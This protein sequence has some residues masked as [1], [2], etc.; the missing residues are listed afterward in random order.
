[1]AKQAKLGD[2]EAYRQQLVELAQYEDER[3]Q[4]IADLPGSFKSVQELVAIMTVSLDR[5]YLLSSVQ[6]LIGDGLAD[7]EWCGERCYT[8]G[9]FIRGHAAGSTPFCA[10]GAVYMA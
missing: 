2:A 3:W 4:A 10:C 6:R 7:A 9:D 1:M 8:L 5:I